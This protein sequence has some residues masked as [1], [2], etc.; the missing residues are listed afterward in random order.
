[1]STKLGEDTELTMPIKTIVMVVAF[2]ISSSWYVFNTQS[3]ISSLESDIAVIQ[4]SVKLNNE[5]RTVAPNAP[6]LIDAHTKVYEIQSSI[7]AIMAT[8]EMYAKQ[9]SRGHTDIEV[10][11]STVGFLQKQIDDI[12]GE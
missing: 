11:K 2:L 3:K 10:L 8:L 9:P 12:K 4:E 7:N 6:Q 5:F 1:M